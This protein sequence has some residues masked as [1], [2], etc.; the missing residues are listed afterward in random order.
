MPFQSILDRWRTAG[1]TSEANLAQTALVTFDSCHPQ[2][3]A[4][5]DSDDQISQ[6]DREYLLE[7]VILVYVEDARVV[8]DKVIDCCHSRQCSGRPNATAQ[9]ATLGH[10]EERGKTEAPFESTAFSKTPNVRRTRSSILF[11]DKLLS[12]DLAGQKSLLAGTWLSRRIMWSFYQP[13]RIDTPFHHVDK[14]QSELIRRLGLGQSKP[15]EELLLW[16]HRLEPHQTAHRPS[17]FDAEINEFFRPGGKTVPLSG[18]DGLH[19]VVHLQVTG[20]QLA[21]RI[22]VAS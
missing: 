3:F 12:A 9:R 1:R 7:Q 14:R 2:V 17:T 6:S 4:N 21:A 5:L 19:E 20:N 13:H 16:E 8:V 18:T 10:V 15:D 11:L 22:E